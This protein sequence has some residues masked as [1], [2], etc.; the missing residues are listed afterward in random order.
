MKAVVIVLA[1][2]LAGV[3][4]EDPIKDINK[5]YIKG[6][7]IENGFDPQQYPT[8]LRNAKVPEK[9]E[10]NRN[11][12]YSCMMKKMNLMKADGSLNE[13][14]LRQKFNMN[15]DTLGKALSTCKDQVKDDKCKLAACLMA[16]RGA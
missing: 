13:D 3:F 12:Y 2:C 11:C 8:G 10:Q 16:N 7:L 1:V 6:C 15:L 9:Q 5:E 4:A 14:A